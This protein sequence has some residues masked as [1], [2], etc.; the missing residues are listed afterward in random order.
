MRA[1]NALATQHNQH[2]KQLN[3]D[4]ADSRPASE[5]CNADMSACNHRC[6]MLVC[7]VEDMDAV[8]RERKKA[9]AASAPSR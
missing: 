4:A 8:M 5:A 9:A 6:A 7:R 2:V 1:F 3:Q